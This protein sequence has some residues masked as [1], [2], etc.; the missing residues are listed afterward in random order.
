MIQ[1]KSNI[2]YDLWPEF[3]QAIK[4]LV[5]DGTY[6]TYVE[7]HGDLRTRKMKHHNMHGS[8]RF[9]AWHRAYLI[10]FERELRKVNSKLSIPYWDWV[11]DEG[12]MRNFAEINLLTRSKRRLSTKSEFISRY[13]EQAVEKI[14]SVPNFDT[15]SRD[16]EILHNF[17]HI[18]VGG[19]MASAISPLDPAFWLHHAQIDKIWADWQKINGNATKL[20]NLRGDEHKLGPWEDEFDVTNVNNTKNLQGDSYQ[21][22]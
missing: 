1:R 19:D 22:V 18:W 4:K 14:L 6:Y 7:F 17:G 8:L 10:M 11:K 20:A 3:N 12:D 13:D 15:F 16:L 5:E 2:D 9:L 21:Y